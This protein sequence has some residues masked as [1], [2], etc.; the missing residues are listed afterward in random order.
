[1]TDVAIVSCPSY[2]KEDVRA[3][4]NAVLE[5]FGGLDWVMPNM[6]IAI[7]ANLVSMMKPEAAA[8]THPGLL[9]ELVQMLTERGAKVIIG[10]SVYHNVNQNPGAVPKGFADFGS[11]ILVTGGQVD[12]Y[13]FVFFKSDL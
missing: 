1:M 11:T 2:Q 3:A 13:T 10:D 4:L 12:I 6:R 5:P 7:K 8:T 9:C